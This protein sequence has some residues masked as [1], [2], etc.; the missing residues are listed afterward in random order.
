MVGSVKMA[1]IS[2]LLVATAVGVCIVAYH[3]TV[4]DLI[5][6]WHFAGST[7]YAHGGLLFLLGVYLAFERWRELQPPLAPSMAAV[8]FVL[9]LSV[10]WLI[11]G[12]VFVQVLQLLA[13]LALLPVTAWALLGLRGFCPLAFP[14]A[15]PILGLPIWEVLNQGELQV[16]TAIGVE[17]LLNFSGVPVGREGVLL[18]IP[19]G[20][21]R[22]AENCSGMRQLVVSVPVA[23]VAAYLVG[24]RLWGI[25]VCSFVGGCVALLVNT[26]RIYVVV[27]AGHLTEMQHYF[28]TTDH[29]VLGWVMF[30]IAITALL[31]LIASRRGTRAQPRSF[32]T[33]VTIGERP[34]LLIALFVALLV[35]P[36]L[37]WHFHQLGPREDSFFTLPERMG[38]WFLVPLQTDYEP[39]HAEPD[40]IANASYRSA[41]YG[42]VTLRVASFTQQVQGREAVSSRNKLADQ[43]MWQSTEPQSRIDTGAFTVDEVLVTGAGQRL[44]IWGW[45]R[46]PVGSS[47]ALW[48]AKG[49]ELWSR[50]SNPG[51]TFIVTL[52][53][54]EADDA[55]ASQAA[56]AAF[57]DV[58]QAPLTRT[59]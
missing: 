18:H 41:Q 54:A 29:I 2:A 13:V 27:L 7:G 42:V 22:V 30:V 3:S 48:E 5:D 49:L 28:V 15:L 8:L 10:A 44:R 32:G 57:V 58:L 1:Q 23:A 39:V 9:I 19:A 43:I 56:L 47:S 11:A 38:D 21:F 55:S 14:L 40:R 20:V 50:F 34:G 17:Q 35:G 4:S 53:R 52:A 6:L 16:F 59:F 25:V 46:T 26:L 36:L 33:E 37:S 45:Y 51:E 31:L 12:L 24:Y